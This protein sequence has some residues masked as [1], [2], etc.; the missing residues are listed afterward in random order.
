MF[1]RKVLLLNASNK[2]DFPVYPYAFIQVPAI[3]RQAGIEVVCKDLL[4]IPHDTWT[5]VIRKMIERHSPSMILITLRNTDSLNA[6][7][8]E[9]NGSKDGES[10]AYFP[11]ERTKE[12]IAAIR[13]ISD[14][15][16]AVGGF[17]FSLLSDEL[18]CY[19]R[20]D[21]GVFEGPNDFFAR[22]EEI[23]NGNPP[24]AAN[25]LY[26]QGDQL[27]S[28]PRT[29]YPPL[30]GAEY[31]SQ[32]IE[33]MMEFYTVFP[34][35]GFQGAAV[36]VMRGCNHSCVFCAEP[37]GKGA[38]VRYRD[39]SAVMKDVEILARHGI[40]RLYI[41]SS[42]LNPE[43]N[44][45]ILEF[46]DRI[47]AFNASR[48]EEEKITWFGANY[49]LK[50]ETDEFERLYRSGFTGGWFDITALDD[51]NAR[52]MRTPYRN[53]RLL[54]HLKIYADQQKKQNKLLRE[55]KALRKTEVRA[56]DGRE[57]ESIRWSMFLGNP[58]TTIATICNTIRIANQE[59]LTEIFDRCAI[60]EITRVFDYEVPDEATLAVTY[61]VAPELK[62]FGYQ[63]ILP[64]FAHPPALLQEFSAKEISEMFSHIAATYLSKRYQQTRDWHGFIKQQATAASLSSWMMELG[65]AA[66]NS[67]DF[68][69]L[70]TERTDGSVNLN[71]NQTAKDVVNLLVSAGVGEFPGF[72]ESLGLPSTMDTL[73]QTTSYELAKALYGKWELAEELEAQTQAV[74]PEWKRDLLQFCFQAILYRFNILINPKYRKLF[75][76]P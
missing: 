8:Y 44:D 66:E 5:Q 54:P 47:H 29:L 19:L 26:F 18:M 2:K 40:T 22:F 50:F 12:L 46:A 39:L 63:Q 49:L 7:D 16:I 36:E 62:R 55:Q 6:P 4:G 32:A 23:R 45:F 76:S 53:A 31:T 13:E 64:S 42:E 34:S 1:N 24:Q 17:G 3:A 43:G 68:H 14:L 27:I 71:D 74:S 60:E 25:L 52:A 21:F 48:A 30:A 72:F 37:H 38:K 57:D 41:V 69:E 33:A 51:E 15:K 56:G 20:P 28:N 11:I 9:A 65:Q 10:S 35:P 59:G 75:V 67:A 73:N 70:F 61:S 58:A